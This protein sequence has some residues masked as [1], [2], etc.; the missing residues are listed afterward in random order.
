MSAIEDKFPRALWVRLVIYIALG[1][2]FGGFL[3]L[4]FEV[5]AK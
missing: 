4:L 3:Y 5:G 2:V 1:H